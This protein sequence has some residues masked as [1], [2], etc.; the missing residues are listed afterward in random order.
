MQPVSGQPRHI[1]RPSF[2]PN[3][4]C[5]HHHPT[6]NGR[7]FIL[8]GHYNS[9]SWG[10]TRRYR[11]KAC[12][13]TCSNQT[14]SIDYWAHRWIDY[15]EFDNT[16]SG[17]TG[18]RQAGRAKN[19]SYPLIRNRVLRLARNYL[20]AF[21]ACQSGF[22]LPENIAFDGFESYLRSQYFPTN[23]NIAV[24]T[25][26]QVPY[27]F[28]LSLMRRKGTMTD[29]Q[30]RNRDIIDRH[31]RP[32]PH[33]LVN[34]C[35]TVFRD[36]LSLLMNRGLTRAFTLFTDQK[37]EYPIALNELTEYRHL[38]QLKLVDHHTISSRAKRTRRNPLFPVNYLDRELRKNSAA[39]A[40]ETVRQDREVSMSLS[41]MAI[42]LGYHTFKKP[43]RITNRLNN[44]T[45]HAQRVNLA[46]TPEA[47]KALNE[48]Y[49]HRHV[50]THQHLN[51]QW[52]ADVWLMRKKNPPI[53]SFRT[54]EVNPK[55]Q[56]GNGWVAAHLTA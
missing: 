14:F 33:D 40:R 23:F 54:G 11:C 5:R 41:R 51:A 22:K 47:K 52:M 27:A 15:A 17:C 42:T 7:W 55:G 38:S 13:R 48:L 30:K 24:G 31:W 26:S 45:T 8:H 4:H 32:E 43:F 2:C 36:T 50:W 16:L 39:H 12:G 46:G 1:T 20:N 10:K 53:V 29:T 3:Q 44:N 37:S 9:N 35:K 18:Y 49:T 25:D 28:T 56:P 19:W 34:S 6:E 21:D